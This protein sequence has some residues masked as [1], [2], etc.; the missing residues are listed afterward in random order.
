MSACEFPRLTSSKRSLFGS[1]VRSDRYQVGVADRTNI[2]KI[3][4]QESLGLARHGHELDLQCGR[5]REFN[6][7]A[8]VTAL[9]TVSRK[10]FVQDDGIEEFERH[11]FL[12]CRDHNPRND[13][14]AFNLCG[15]INYAATVDRFWIAVATSFGFAP[16]AK[17]ARSNR[18]IDTV[19]SAASILATRD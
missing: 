13:L 5:V 8:N 11:V 1:R 14:R 9:E 15:Q 18:S 7:G 4:G 19:A 6:H 16:N 17:S 3:K 10:I 12:L 2:G